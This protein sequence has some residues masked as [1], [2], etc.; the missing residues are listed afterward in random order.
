MVPQNPPKPLLV[1]F[2]LSCLKHLA[3]S[4]A[5]SVFFFL[6]SFDVVKLN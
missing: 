6:F 4:I 1:F 2:I 5:V 3:L